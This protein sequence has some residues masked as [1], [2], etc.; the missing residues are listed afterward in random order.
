MRWVRGFPALLIVGSVGLS[1]PSPCAAAPVLQVT[2]ITVPRGGLGDI[3]VWGEISGESTFGV[4]ILVELIPRPG[5]RGTVRFTPSESPADSDIVQLEAV[6]I[7]ADRI[8]RDPITNIA[9]RDRTGSVVKLDLVE[10][11]TNFWPV[12]KMVPCKK[13]P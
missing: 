5:T 2:D 10:K 12:K 13:L 6:Q 4:S 7:V 1:G 3:V 8:Y 9:E 11:S